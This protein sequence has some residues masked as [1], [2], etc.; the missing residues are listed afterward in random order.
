MRCHRWSLAGLGLLLLAGG[1]GDLDAPPPPPDPATLTRDVDA[2]AARI[3]QGADVQAA[4]F[5]RTLAPFE[6]TPFDRWPEGQ[7]EHLVSSF[8]HLRAVLIS[9]YRIVDE[10]C[11][12]DSWV[13]YSLCQTGYPCVVQVQLA[14]LNCLWYVGH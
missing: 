13:R 5:S 4:E 1:C 10:V 14:E 2:L 12:D 7:L 8:Q 11:T 3:D 9:R 6:T